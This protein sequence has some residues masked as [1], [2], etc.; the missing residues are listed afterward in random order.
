VFAGPEDGLLLVYF[1]FT[2][3][4]DVCPGTMTAVKRALTELGDEAERVRV[5]MV[6]VDPDRDVPGLTDFV[7]SFVSDAHAIASEDLSAVRRL[8]LSFG[9][10]FVSREGRDPE[11]TDALYAVDDAGRLVLT[12]P[13][14][15]DYDDIAGDLEQLLDRVDDA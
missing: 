9:A 4:P 6:S 2:N 8:A 13:Y 1:G 5:A 3:C 7:Q 14:P 11:H 12:W 15:T 10:D